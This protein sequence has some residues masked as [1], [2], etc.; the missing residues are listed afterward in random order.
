[1]PGPR[2]ITTSGEPGAITDDSALRHYMCLAVVRKG[3]G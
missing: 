1:L 2:G 3:A